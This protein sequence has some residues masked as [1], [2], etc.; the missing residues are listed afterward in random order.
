MVGR[1]ERGEPRY[2][3]C[4]SHSWSTL[5]DRLVYASSIVVL[6]PVPRPGL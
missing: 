5:Q 4:A 1:E 3:A 2:I 6:F